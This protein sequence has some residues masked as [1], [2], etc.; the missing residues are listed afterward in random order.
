MVS[1]FDAEDYKVLP[2]LREYLELGGARLE[3]FTK[4]MSRLNPGEMVRTL[5]F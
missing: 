3:I 5:L 2:R 4:P 1:F